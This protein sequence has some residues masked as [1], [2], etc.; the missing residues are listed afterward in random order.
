LFLV[1]AARLKSAAT[2]RFG[3]S[4]TLKSDRLRQPTDGFFTSEIG[5]KYLEYIGNTYLA[6]FPGCPPLLL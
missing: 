5:I 2:K 6:G 3:R 1:E 4:Q